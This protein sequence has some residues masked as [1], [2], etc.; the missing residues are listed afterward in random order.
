[1][2]LGEALDHK[3]QTHMRCFLCSIATGHIEQGTALT[4]WLDASQ[5][6]GNDPDHAVILRDQRTAAEFGRGTYYFITC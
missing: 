4:S 5:V 2:D 6:Y 3:S 1:M